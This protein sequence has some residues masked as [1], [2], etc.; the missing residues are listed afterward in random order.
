MESRHAICI[1]VDGLRASALG[2]YGNTSYGTPQLDELSTGAVLAE[3]LYA[4]SPTVSGFYRNVWQG[5]HSLRT[6]NWAGFPTLPQALHD[7][8]VKQWLIT[9]DA[10][11]AEQPSV[12]YFDEKVF[13]EPGKDVSAASTD[14]THMARFFTL[15]V[16]QLEQ[17]RQESE[18]HQASSLLWLH[19][20]GF[21]AAWDA[22]QAIRADLLEEGDP[23]VPH[24][25]LPPQEVLGVQNPDELL[26]YRVAY[27]A[28]VA[29]LDA[30]V[31]AFYEEAQH[32][33]KDIET[34]VML[35]G[36]RGFALGE[37]ASVGGHCQQLYSEELHLPWLLKKIGNSIPMPRLEGVLQPTDIYATILDWFGLPKVGTDADGTSALTSLAGSLETV[38]HLAVSINSQK[39]MSVRTPAWMLISSSPA[40]QCESTSSQSE[41][42]A[43]LYV[44]PDDRWEFN[45]VASRCPEIVNL[46]Q[47]ELSE[48]IQN[49]SQGIRP[50]T[51]TLPEELIAP[52]R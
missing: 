51:R 15:A 16:E 1:V 11:L 21:N 52:Q 28:Q 49:C 22:P 23:E 24:F 19:H 7:A 35:M 8:G 4:D 41:Q 42:P 17:W 46:M 18:E 44:K 26:S 25:V 10:W 37:H 32:A 34:L 13:V 33:C 3:W 29:V 36:S 30:C 40:D 20:T 5:L 27:A 48:Y 2:T 39:M 45:D 43:E 6:E 47:T 12:S 14:E 31:G 38:R 9:D 50:N